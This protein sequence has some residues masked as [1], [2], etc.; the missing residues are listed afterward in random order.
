M[1]EIRTYKMT[2]PSC[3]G[4]P[5][6]FC[7]ACG[8]TGVQTVTEVETVPKAPSIVIE[9][10]KKP[11]ERNR[12]GDIDEILKR[13]QKR[14]KKQREIGGSKWDHEGIGPIARWMDM[15]QITL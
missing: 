7:P 9:K 1:R 4:V 3:Q 15:R 6:V 13:I 8:S 5:G 12:L 2:C 11:Y 14:E 10:E